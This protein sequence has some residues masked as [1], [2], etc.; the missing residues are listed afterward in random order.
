LSLDPE[1]TER[2][3]KGDRSGRIAY[4]FACDWVGR[5]AMARRRG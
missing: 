3:K 5:Q 4:P 1:L 2:L